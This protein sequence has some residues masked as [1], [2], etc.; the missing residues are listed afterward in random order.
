MRRTVLGILVLA[1]MA[2]VGSA[3]DQIGG[4][5]VS[6]DETCGY[7]SL[8]PAMEAAVPADATVQMTL[9][10]AGAD[11]E[12]AMDAAIAYTPGGVEMDMTFR[13][14]EEEFALIV[15]ENRVFISDSTSG[16]TYEELDAPD[17]AFPALRS[18]AESMDIASEFAAW[19]AGLEKVEQVGEEEI[20][21]E[22]VCHYSVTVDA[23]DAA[24]A[25]GEPLPQGMPETITY[26]LYLT[27][28]DLMRRATF[29]MGGIEA[30]MNA[31]NWNEPV[32]IKA[33]SGN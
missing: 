4:E 7:D 14:P 25:Q 32:D 18:Q 8:M 22:R 24:E 23:A 9:E 21:G 28:N 6:N 16:G 10:M 13:G 5:Q 12:I 26:E 2:L 11:Q 31:T 19:N 27:A 33:P 29:E 30:E 20:D 17:P 1:P 3:E 15:V